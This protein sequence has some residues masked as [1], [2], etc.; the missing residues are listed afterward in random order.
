MGLTAV[1]ATLIV[2]VL[3]APGPTLRDKGNW[4]AMRPE[5]PMVGQMVAYL[6]LLGYMYLLVTRE[7]RQ[8]R[9]WD[10]LRW[11]WPSGASF[12][13]LAGVLIQVIFII[14]EQFLPLPKETPFEE[15]LR[16]RMSVYLIAVFSVTI[17]PLI[18]ELFF[19]GFLYPVLRRSIGVSAAILATALPFALMHAAQYG[20]SWA[21]VLLIFV[22]G[23]V[24]TGVRERKNSLAAPFLIH[25]AYNGSIVALLFLIPY[26]RR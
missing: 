5:L 23:V 25:V 19:R 12:Y 21:S 13:L 26:Q 8:S 3:I 14:A 20:Y 17:G 7:R 11:N 6:L 22:L 18:E 1:V 2:L 9:F 4:L 10:A 15:L 24:L 16:R